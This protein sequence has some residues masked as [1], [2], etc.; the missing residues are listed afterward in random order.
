MNTQPNESEIQLQSFLQHRKDGKF[1]IRLSLYPQ[2][3]QT[4]ICRAPVNLCKVE[5]HGNTYTFGGISE[6]FYDKMV[7]LYHT[8]K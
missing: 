6:P 4:V 1:I 7:E 2:G 5:G 3:D 8:Y